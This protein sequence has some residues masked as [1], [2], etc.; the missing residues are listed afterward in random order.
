LSL[1]RIATDSLPPRPLVNDI[2]RAALAASA[3]FS[4]PFDVTDAERDALA[5]AIRRGR[6]RVAGLVDHPSALPQ[7]LR[8]SSVGEWRRQ[9][10][11]WA[12]ARE[13]MRVPDYFSLGDLARIG[14]AEA[15]PLP[16][17]DAWGTS[18]LARE[19]CLCLRLPASGGWETL[20]GRAGTS[21]V[22]EQVPDLALRVAESLADLGLPARLLRSV[23]LVATQDVL[24]TYRPAYIDDWSG[25]VA[26]VRRLTDVRFADAISVLT[27][28][29]PLVP[30]DEEGHD[31]ARR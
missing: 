22:A 23:L 7:L 9:V 12:L 29:G 16:A 8:A 11:P 31:D 24:D 30:A 13:P 6:A 17:L 20:S 27:S 4:N 5:D 25:L 15:T 18:A 10:L 1:K 26:T 14:A 2:D 3:V 19:G 21:L 28:G